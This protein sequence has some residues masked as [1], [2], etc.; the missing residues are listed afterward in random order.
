MTFEAADPIQLTASQ[1]LFQAAEK[2]VGEGRIMVKDG[3]IW[4]L[5]YE[6]EDEDAF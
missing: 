2:Q 4:S 1:K 6:K 3:L 5:I